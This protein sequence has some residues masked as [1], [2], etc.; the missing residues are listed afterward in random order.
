MLILIEREAMWIS[1]NSVR[2]FA[3]KV[4]V[5]GINI[6]TGKPNIPTPKRAPQIGDVPSEQFLQEPPPLEGMPLQDYVVPPKQLWL[7]GMVKKVGI[8]EQFVASPID[9]MYAFGAMV[10]S[11]TS[12]IKIKFEITPTKSK[13]KWIFVELVT[14]VTLPRVRLEFNGR[15]NVRQLI[16]ET[17]AK[18]AIPSIILRISYCQVAVE[19]CEWS[20]LYVNQTC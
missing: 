14:E 13:R 15:E 7:D 17:L 6:I 5:N 12:P 18:M 4:F 8:A 9:D 2:P 20:R 16:D 3:V 1:F 10:E 11:Q 19:P